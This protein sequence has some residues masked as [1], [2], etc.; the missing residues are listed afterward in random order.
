[1]P[2]DTRQFNFHVTER[3]YTKENLGSLLYQ[4]NE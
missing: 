1:M 3:K 4:N 2:K